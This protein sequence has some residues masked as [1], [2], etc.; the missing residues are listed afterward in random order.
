MKESRKNV[1][2]FGNI[3]VE[4]SER[5]QNTSLTLTDNKIGKEYKSFR[6]RIDNKTYKNA[7]KKV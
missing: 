2:H 1:E 6:M 7:I 4:N 3:Y 5:I